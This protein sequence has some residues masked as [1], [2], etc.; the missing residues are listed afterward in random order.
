MVVADPQLNV[1]AVYMILVVANVVD[2]PVTTPPAAVTVATGFEA[3]LHVPPGVPELVNVICAPEHT[4]SRPVIVPANAN[5]FTV[6]G[7][8]VVNVPQLNVEDV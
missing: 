5:G 7:W 2:T 1:A 3:L 4:L 8:L 6:T